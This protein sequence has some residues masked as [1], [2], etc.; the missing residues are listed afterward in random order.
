MPRSPFKVQVDKSPIKKEAPT[1]K[2]NNDKK[3]KKK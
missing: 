1:K 2:K 3:S